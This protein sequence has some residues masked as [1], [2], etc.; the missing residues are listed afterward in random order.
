M[1]RSIGITCLSISFCLLSLSAAMVH[2]QPYPEQAYTDDHLQP[3]RRGRG[4]Q[5]KDSDAVDVE[6]VLGQQI[7]AMNKPGASDTIGTDALAKSRKDGYTLGYTSSARHGL[8]PGDRTG[9]RPLRPG[10]GF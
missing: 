6:K 2:A 9:R 3:G 7:I 4:C 1:K 8:R 5:C 10:Q